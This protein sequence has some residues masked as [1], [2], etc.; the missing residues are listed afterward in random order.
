MN[1][2]KTILIYNFNNH[3]L[4]YDSSQFLAD[5]LKKFVSLAISA[6][7]LD[8]NYLTG[9]LLAITGFQPLVNITL[10]EIE[11][12]HCED[13]DFSIPM[14]GIKFQRGIVYDYFNFFPASR[15]YFM[16]D[17]Y[18]PKLVYDETNKLISI[19]S[20]DKNDRQIRINKNVICGLDK[21]GNLKSLLILI[22]II[23]KG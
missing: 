11:I 19:G 22:D 20:F 1:D 13:G 14:N 6:I 9:N 10:D 5:D 21:N 15:E 18:N 3:R 8:F 7:E 12:P 2:S 23:I 4:Y 17:A 16:I